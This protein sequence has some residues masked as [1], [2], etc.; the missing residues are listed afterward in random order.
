M[1]VYAMV[2]DEPLMFGP[3]VAAGQLVHVDPPALGARYPTARGVGFVHEPEL[4]ETVRDYFAPQAERRRELLDN[5]D[6]IRE[7]LTKGADKAKYA[8]S[9]T[10][11]KVRKKTGLVY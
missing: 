11:R 6:G 2:V 10:L 4:F 3:G 9:K 1:F 8:A 7:I 5:P